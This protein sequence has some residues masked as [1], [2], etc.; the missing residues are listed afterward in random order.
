LFE[1]R[2]SKRAPLHATPPFIGPDR[3]PTATGAAENR[4]FIRRVTA[5]IAVG[6]IFVVAHTV[7]DEAL[8]RQFLIPRAARLLYVFLGIVGAI[9]EAALVAGLLALTVDIYLKRRLTQEITQDVSA[10]VMSRALPRE[11]QDEVDAFCREH[12]VRTDLELNYTF[13][14]IEGNENFILMSVLLRFQVVNLTDESQPFDHIAS[15]QITPNAMANAHEAMVLI[16]EAGA[17]DVFNEDGSSADYTER[18]N[19]DLGKLVDGVYRVWRKRVFVPPKGSRKTSFFWSY[20]RQV[21]PREFQDTFILTN[22]AIRPRLQVTCP[23]WM[24]VSAT[25]GHRLKADA[26]TSG[27]PKFW[28]LNAGMPPFSS[29]SI[30]WRNKGATTPVVPIASVAHTSVEIPIMSPNQDAKL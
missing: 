5:L 30:E 8:L 22:A 11:L 29:I 10:Y 1:I 6:F 23:D 2:S 28:I 14:D 15:V 16:P 21:L 9:G 4:R 19:P 13:S 24:D 18:G 17:R 3:R 26:F 7:L 20:R 12:S 25:F 27:N